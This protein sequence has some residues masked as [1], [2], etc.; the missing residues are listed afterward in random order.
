MVK[1]E[2]PI[3]RGFNPDPSIIRVGEDYYIATSTFEWFPG[4]MIYHSKN[5]INWELVA[6]PLNRMSQLDMVGVPDSGGIYAP[7]LSYDKGVF[8]LIY[9]NVHKMGA[10]KDLDNFL[11]T[12]E[13]ILGDWSEPIYLNSTGIDPSL[14]HDDDGK[15]W[16]VN[17]KHKL[18]ED[19]SPVNKIVLQ[20]YSIKEKKL[21]GERTEI[22]GG[23]KLGIVEGAHLYKH[24]EYYYL[25]TAE[26]GTFS[27]HAVTMCRSK[28]IKGIY[29]VDPINPILTS[30]FDPI[31]SIQSSGHADIVESSNGQWY[32]VHLGRRPISSRGMSVLGRETCIQKVYWTEDAWLRLE[33]G[34]NTP[35]TFVE[36]D[37]IDDVVQIV[38][39]H[40]HNDFS[41]DKLDLSMQTLRIPLDD[42][43]M[44]LTE[45]KGYLRLTGKNN[46]A[47]IIRQAHVARR[48][49]SFV[50]TAETE[51]EF[52]PQNERTKA[53]LT[54]Y[55]NMDNFLFFN[56]D[57]DDDGQKRL[58]LL[59]CTGK[60][61]KF[62]V[63]P[64]IID[65]DKKIKLKVKVHFDRARFYYSQK[66]TSDGES[67]WEDF[68][69][70]FEC[71]NLSDEFV[72]SFDKR[73]F[74]G[75]FVGLF[76]Q[77]SDYLKSKAYFSYFDHKEYGDKSVDKFLM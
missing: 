21:V 17:C 72:I 35:E 48:W 26:G 53:G 44:S 74:T 66:Q 12:T 14:F 28:N 1:L 37:G 42:E 57:R 56:I 16:L 60:V 3:I 20:E 77:D 64:V 67:I 23:T 73:A 76:C 27:G 71:H 22:F 34:K 69:G 61:P 55:Y 50:F 70:D 41:K 36:I 54:L 52:D 24:G 8:Y 30:R 13:D 51:V 46:M 2:N 49:Q 58:S 19:G 39:P 29:E 11:V 31:L 18:T 62:F 75:A 65:E 4:V 43:V 32:M 15:K 6:C 10:F 59:L 5:L 47:S 45:R 33:N 7:C 63:N 40:Y 38:T 25:L 68:G 9:T